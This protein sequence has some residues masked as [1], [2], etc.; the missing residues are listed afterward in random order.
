MSVLAQ[1]KQFHEDT[2]L[3]EIC[4]EIDYKV[5]V[6]FELP[7]SVKKPSIPDP[8]KFKGSKDHREFMEWLT[9]Y[10]DYL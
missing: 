7:K 6:E 5:G 10:L 9:K 8:P 1:A 3:R 2:L 4:R